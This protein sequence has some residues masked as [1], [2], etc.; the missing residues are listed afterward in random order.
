MNGEGLGF[1]VKDVGFSDQDFGSSVAG[2]GVYR[3]TSLISNCPPP[4]DHRRALCIGLPQGPRRRLFLMSE[5][6]LYVVSPTGRAGILRHTP[7][8]ADMTAARA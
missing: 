7:S 2:C 6:P 4:L 1:R 3:G 5:V 8:L